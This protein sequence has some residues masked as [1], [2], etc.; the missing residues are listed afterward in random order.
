MDKVDPNAATWQEL[1]TLPNI[2]EKRAKEIVEYRRQFEQL[3]P[4]RAAFAKA[5]DLLPIRGLGVT[6][7]GG[8]RPHLVFPSGAEPA[9]ADP[10]S[11]AVTVGHRVERRSPATRPER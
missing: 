11:S 3:H 8:L 4:G 10:T 2:G 6:L 5:E 1:A 9:A 7:V